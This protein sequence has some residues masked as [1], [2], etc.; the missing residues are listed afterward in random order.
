[1][2]R[3]EHDSIR[4]DISLL[5]KALSGGSEPVSC[6]KVSRITISLLSQ[7]TL[8]RQ[9]SLIAGSCVVFSLEDMVVHTAGVSSPLFLPKPILHLHLGIPWDAMTALLVL[10]DESSWIVQNLGE[11]FRA[12]ILASKSPLVKEVRA[13]QKL[14]QC[15][16][17][18]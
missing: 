15:G 7:R 12:G 4:P 14:P 5:G 9:S 18:R 8:S 2:L 6:P 17:H 16:G 13:W 11:I 1:M 3:C 10:V